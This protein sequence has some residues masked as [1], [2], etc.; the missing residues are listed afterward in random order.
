MVTT[1]RKVQTLSE[2][3]LW[4]GFAGAE[5]FENGDE[6]VYVEANNFGILASVNGTEAYDENG[7]AWQLLLS[8]PNQACARAFLAGLPN[9]FEPATFGFERY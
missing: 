5:R 7:T 9:D 2:G 3:D 4:E 6:P 1:E 8:F